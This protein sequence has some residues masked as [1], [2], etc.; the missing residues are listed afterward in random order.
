YVDPHR[1][2]Q[3]RPKAS[4]EQAKIAVEAGNL[5]SL[6]IKLHFR[7]EA[8]RSDAARFRQVKLL[9]VENGPLDRFK[10][11][12]EKMVGHILTMRKRDQIESAL[13]WTLTKPEVD[14][15][16]G[17]MERLKSLIN[18]ALTNDLLYR[19]L[20]YV[21]DWKVNTGS[22][23]PQTIHSEGV[24]SRAQIEHITR[25]SERLQLHID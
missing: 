14:D 11:I 25:H 5:Y 6:L 12:L 15:A 7:V 20:Q 8:A 19:P 1:S 3:R 9:G 24:A 21:R 23:L 13:T 17:R 16:L 18:Y 22:M 2:H 4:R 10:S